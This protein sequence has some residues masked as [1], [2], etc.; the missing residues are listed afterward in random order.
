MSDCKTKTIERVLGDK[1]T[2]EAKDRLS[3][4]KGPGKEA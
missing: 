1:K 4:R 2:L 3:N